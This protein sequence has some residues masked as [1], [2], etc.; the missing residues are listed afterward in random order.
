M[1]D[2]EARA[3]EIAKR[4][5]A[6]RDTDLW[7]EDDL[8]ELCEMAGLDA[9]W[10]AAGWEQGKM[11]AY[12]AADKL[13]VKIADELIRIHDQ[14]KAIEEEAGGGIRCIYRMDNATLW[15]YLNT[16]QSWDEVREGALD[17]F[18]ERAGLSEDWQRVQDD[19]LDYE[20]VLRAACDALGFEHLI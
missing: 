2:K 12:A 19:E 9:E 8:A 15:K 3:A 20:S 5:R 18:V 7:D 13:G 4:L 6:D 1:T 14:L 16:C 11:V 17:E 10:E